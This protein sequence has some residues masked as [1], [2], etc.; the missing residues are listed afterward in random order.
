MFL[1]VSLKMVTLK[2][3]SVMLILI[4]MTWYSMGVAT[5]PSLIWH[6]PLSYVM[7]VLNSFSQIRASD[8]KISKEI[9][10]N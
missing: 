8:R 4:S 3:S 1:K 9:R 10:R 6:V 7:R 5:P 2:L